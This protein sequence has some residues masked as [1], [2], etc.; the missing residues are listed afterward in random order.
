MSQCVSESIYRTCTV[1]AIAGLPKHGT[2]LLLYFMQSTKHPRSCSGCQMPDQFFVFWNWKE[3][4]L[5]GPAH[6]NLWMILIIIIYACFPQVSE[7]EETDRRWTEFYANL[8]AFSSWLNQK[9]A[10][11]N[12]IPNSGATPDQQFDQTKVSSYLCYLTI[13][14][15]KFMLQHLPA[16]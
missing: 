11:L 5:Y 8:E 14:Y 9:E 16:S 10:D 4:L 6:S 1:H 13:Q 3:V 2:P 12:D 15:R 7:L